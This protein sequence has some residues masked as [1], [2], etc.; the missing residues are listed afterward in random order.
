VNSWQLFLSS[1]KS[2]ITY[3]LTLMK[4]T[5]IFLFLFSSA[6]AQE[7]NWAAGARIGEPLG[8]N[9]RKYIG[10]EHA[11]DVN[12]GTYGFLYRNNIPYKKGK[13]ES[14]GWALQGHYLW[15]KSIDKND[16]FWAYYG[17]GGQINNRERRDANNLLVKSNI[18]LG[19]S[20]AAGIES[21]FL[22]TGMYLE[23]LPAPLFWHPSVGAGLRLNL[24]KK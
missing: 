1:N 13:Y 18:S 23:I 9:I 21:F 6:M 17:F 22:D 7:N 16:R 19:P 11:I 20:G 14:A 3:H 12:F 2:F 5:F 24:R 10:Y 15:T 8:L 4:K